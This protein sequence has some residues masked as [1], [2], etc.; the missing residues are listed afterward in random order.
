M[1]K[2]RKNAP[3]TRT[4][5]T[6]EPALRLTSR[7]P[8]PLPGLPSAPRS[9]PQEAPH[10]DAGSDGPDEQAHADEDDRDHREA[11]GLDVVRALDATHDAGQGQLLRQE[12]EHDR[13]DRARQAADDALEHEG[14][15]DE[16]VRRADEL[17]HLD[18]TT[19]REDGE[20]DRVR[21]QDRGGDQE[22][23]AAHQEDGPDD[24]RHLEHALGL[25]LAEIG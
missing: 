6:S 19:A 3:T 7:P 2:P 24:G 1:T 22:D 21:D 10:G 17:H 16:P 9:D 4:A 12:Q 8:S 25:L 11:P 15:A 18:L 14:R 23:D 13:D 5:A 20:A